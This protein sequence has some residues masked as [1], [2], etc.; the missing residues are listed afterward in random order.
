VLANRRV[1]FGILVLGSIAVSA[2]K[3]PPEDGYRVVSYDG[4]RKI[5]T[6]V[7]SGFDRA[8]NKYEHTRFVVSCEAYEYGNKGFDHGPDVCSLRVGE[9]FHPDSGAH[10]NGHVFVDVDNNPAT[11]QP[12]L[13]I[14]QGDGK[15]QEVQFL[16]ILHEDDLPK[17]S[18]P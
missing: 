15:A 17:T 6:I 8:A 4:E 1:G 11:N 2:C 14:A 10:G 18:D 5:W 7:Y 12:E 13:Y 3:K 9:F 16:T